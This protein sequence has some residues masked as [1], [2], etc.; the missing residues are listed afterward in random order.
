MVLSAVYG[1]RY[2]AYGI[3]YKVQC[4][5]I[6]QNTASEMPLSYALDPECGIFQFMLSFGHG[7]GRTMRELRVSIKDP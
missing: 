2:I 5:R 6:L 7:W 3:G 4:I 1:I